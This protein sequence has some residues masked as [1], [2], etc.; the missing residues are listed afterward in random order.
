MG[1]VFPTAHRNHEVK[2]ARSNDLLLAHGQKLHSYAYGVTI[3]GSPSQSLI[4]G[5][6]DGM[7]SHWDADQIYRAHRA[8]MYSTM[9]HPRLA[10]QHYVWQGTM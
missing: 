1:L 4:R 9:F 7:F 5:P 10:G 2:S 8:G 3:S 6:D